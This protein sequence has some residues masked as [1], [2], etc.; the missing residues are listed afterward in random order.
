M[1]FFTKDAINVWYIE[2]LTNNHIHMEDDK[3]S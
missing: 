2:N 3:D 1:S